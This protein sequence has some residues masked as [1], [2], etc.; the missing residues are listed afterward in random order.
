[1]GGEWAP[2]ARLGLNKSG[3]DVEGV[4]VGEKVGYGEGELE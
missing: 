2:G 1:L 4:E 3:G